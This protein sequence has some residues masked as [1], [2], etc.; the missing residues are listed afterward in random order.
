MNTTPG[1]IPGEARRYATTDAEGHLPQSVTRWLAAA[2]VQVDFD[3]SKVWYTPH[4]FGRIPAVTVL[5]SSGKQIEASV[6]VTRT[7]VT[8]VLSEPLAGSILLQ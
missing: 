3:A 4:L 2:P 7:D 1:A 8:V 5:D 6:T